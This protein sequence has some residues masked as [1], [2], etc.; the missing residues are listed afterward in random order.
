[1]ENVGRNQ[2]AAEGNDHGTALD[3]DMGLDS[4]FNNNSAIEQKTFKIQCYNQD[5]DNS[6]TSSPKEH[7]ENYLVFQLFCSPSACTDYDL[8]GQIVWPVSG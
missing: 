8:T 5:G 1:M 2:S 4:L 6:P 7:N 3:Y